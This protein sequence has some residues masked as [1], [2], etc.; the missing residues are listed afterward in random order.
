ML[1]AEDEGRLQHLLPIKYGRMVASRFAFLRGSAGVMAADLAS[2]PSPE[3]HTQLC[4]DAHIANFGV[5]ATPERLLVFDIDDFD[6]PSRVR[7]SGTSRGWLRVS[8]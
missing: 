6:R 7:S 4:G 1:Q 8:S 2:S 5:F 3:I